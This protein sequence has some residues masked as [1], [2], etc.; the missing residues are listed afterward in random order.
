MPTPEQEAMAL[1]KSAD[2]EVDWELFE[3]ERKR[4][5]AEGHQQLLADARASFRAMNGWSTVETEEEWERTVEQADDDFDSG[6]FLIDRLGAERHLDP[7]LMAVLL[8]LRRRLIEENNATTAA[9]V[10]MVDS[11]VLRYY[12]LLRVNGWIGNL[13]QWLEAEFFRKEPMSAKFKG[14]YGTGKVRGLEVEDLVNQ[15]VERLMPLLDRSNRMMLRNLKALRAW[16]QS[17]VPNVNVGSAGQVNMAAQQVNVAPN[18]QLK[19]ADRTSAADR[20]Q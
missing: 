1:A 14:W 3:N 12:H 20:E 17:P 5:L 11:A 13:A 6:E 16:S 4:L 8:T 19:G 15:I 7:P 10:L 2:G 9:E 18:E